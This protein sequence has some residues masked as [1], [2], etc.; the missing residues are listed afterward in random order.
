MFVEAK[1]EDVEAISLHWFHGFRNEC[2]VVDNSKARIRKWKFPARYPPS[3]G[4]FF[5]QKTIFPLTCFSENWR[6][7][8]LGQQIKQH[9]PHLFQ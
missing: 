2:L 1:W 6:D 7:S 4:G 3:P 8:E 5:P 9:A